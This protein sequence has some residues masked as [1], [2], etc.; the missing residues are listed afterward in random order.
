MREAGNVGF[1]HPGCASKRKDAW[2]AENKDLVIEVG[3]FCKLGFP[4]DPVGGETMYEW[5]WV[6]VTQL[7]SDNGMLCGV[8]N[9]DPV[10]STTVKCGSVVEFKFEEITEHI[11]GMRP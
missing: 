5:M 9:N 8:L 2:Q 11:P 1:I 7:V 6:K 10:F 4:L 3:D